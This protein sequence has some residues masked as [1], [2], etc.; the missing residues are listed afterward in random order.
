MDIDPTIRRLPTTQKAVT[1]AIL[2]SGIANDPNGC[3][4][5][6]MGNCYAA[7]QLLAIMATN[8]NI[9]DVGSCKA[10]RK[11]FDLD[12]LKMDNAADRGDYLHLVDDRV[13]M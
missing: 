5:L 10:K 3:R 6:Y 12:I 9:C 8:W 1:N 2:K 7:P 13:G 4:F 11:G